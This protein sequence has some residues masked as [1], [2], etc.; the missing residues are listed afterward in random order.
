[1]NTNYSEGKSIALIELVRVVRIARHS[2][3]LTP[4]RERQDKDSMAFIIGTCMAARARD[5]WSVAYA[6]CEIRLTS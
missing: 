5:L 2:N 4:P 6:L 1:M 3:D